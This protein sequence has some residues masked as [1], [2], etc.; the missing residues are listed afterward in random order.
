M[1]T[2][3]KYEISRIRND[4][5]LDVSVTEGDQSASVIIDN[6]N[7]IVQVCALAERWFGYKNQDLVGEH[8]KTL[9]ASTFDYP[10]PI[11]Q[12]EMIQ[13]ERTIRVTFR[14]K[15]GYFFPGT[16]TIKDLANDNQELF[17]HPITPWSHTNTEAAQHLLGDTSLS[18]QFELAGKMGGWQLDVVTNQV[19]WTDGVYSIF[20][21]DK[22]EAITPEHILYY[23]HD[24]QPRIRA[25]FQQCLTSGE[26]FSIE[27]SMLNA[28]QQTIWV[29]LTGKAHTVK[30]QITH[31]SGS[32]QDISEL[33]NA[34][35][36]QNQLGDYLAGVLDSTEDLVLALDNQLNVI[37]FN[38][39]YQKQFKSI[40]GFS[41]AVGDALPEILEAYPN[42]RR[43]YQRLWERA[44]ERD[45]FC[46]EMPLAQR[47]EDIPIYEMRFSRINNAQG[48]R[49][50]A[51]HIARN[52]NDRI[53]DQ[54][55]LNYL[56]K[57]D[58]LTGTFNRREF[59]VR[60][61]RCLTNAQQRESTHALL[62]MELDQFKEV[63]DRCGHSAGDELLRQISRIINDKIRQRDAFARIGGDEFAAI[64]ENC[65]TPEAHRV[66]ENVRDAIAAYIFEYEEQRFNVGVS[67][68][69][70][71]ITGESE[72]TEELIRIAD[73]TRYA[74]KVAGRNR[75]HSY[76]THRE[77]RRVELKQSKQ[78][79]QMIQKAVRGGDSLQ[80]SYQQIRPVNSAVWGDYFEVL[81]RI[82][83]TEGNLIM[84][85]QFIHI[86]QRFDIITAFDQA[87]IYKVM[88][89][90]AQH[91]E[92][93]HRR[94]LCSI[95]I[96][97]ESMLD[98]KLPIFIKRQL[99]QFGVEAETLC[100]ELD[101]QF[102]VEHFAEAKAFAE[103]I[104]ELGCK[105]AID[106][107]GKTSIGYQYLADIPASYI[108]IDGALIKSM[109][110][111]PVK[112][113]IVESIQ[114]IANLTG[115]QTIAGNVEDHGTL[116]D[117]R[118]MGIHFGQGF[119]ISKP[120]PL[121]EMV[122]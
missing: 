93:E 78:Q 53:K 63:S 47:E 70:V 100:F 24:E 88:Q 62:Y 5:D 73:S 72:S 110:D 21:I 57:H 60:L 4:D 37:T 82:Q 39:A 3:K 115:K 66:A 36:K 120:K 17:Q 25:A 38:N 59:Q 45:H 51:A 33:Y 32:I 8:F 54:E 91:N 44:L 20:A 107:V 18:E 52:I 84:P 80:L 13:N 22:N 42:E 68:G 43:I 35:A 30:D 116:G 99:N 26:P 77:L 9:A 117:I 64:L 29:K 121:D 81:A 101:E 58:P 46:V 31:L 114:K 92:L 122:A 15:T 76:N 7:N 48:E 118:R 67:I 79:I 27:A 105:T 90:L 41:I 97:I 109:H 2:M 12:E 83:D 98:P 61:A 89:W 111:D 50:G 86:A 19:S 85:A 113:V 16:I 10:K 40:F 74:A 106:N 94:K 65:S 28:E 69:L 108:K 103:A 71:P 119:G 96:A 102:V 14:H 112:Q 87:V 75:V 1:N 23:F 104:N 55:K 11:Q 95:N 49:L 34:K 6:G 56:A